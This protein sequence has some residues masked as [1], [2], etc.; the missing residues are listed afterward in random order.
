MIYNLISACGNG[1]DILTIFLL[2]QGYTRKE[3]AKMLYTTES[4]I[5][6]RLKRIKGRMEEL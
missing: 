1:Q 4:V 3:V 5:S 6:R 2:F